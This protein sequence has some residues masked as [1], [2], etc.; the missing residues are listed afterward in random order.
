MLPH[1]RFNPLTREWVLVSP[2]RT[3]RPWQG[4]VEQGAGGQRPAYDPNCYLC[5]GNERAGGTRNPAYTD[6]YV[7]DNDYPALVPPSADGGWPMAQGQSPIP[8]YQLPPTTPSA[9]FLSHP[10]AGLCRVICFSPRHDLSLAELPEPALRRV[11]DAWAEQTTELNALPFIGYVQVFEN[12]GEMM[13]AS[14][15]HPH[16][17]VWASQHLPNEPA[18]ED[19]ALAAYEQAHGRCLV[20]DLV[21]AELAAGERVVCANEHFAAVVPFWAVWPFETLV[22]G[23]RHL[24]RLDELSA[25]ERDALAS[26]LKRLATRYDNLFQTSFPYSMGWHQRPAA[27]LTLAGPAWHLHAHFY[28]PLLRSATVRKFMVGYELMANP[29][30]DLTAEAAA[31]RLRA[32]PE[33]HYK[34]SQGK[35]A[36]GG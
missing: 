17:Q 23:R 15:P 34:D 19:A 16:G 14:N 4:Q 35:P 32:M 6:I 30:R 13:G 24:G 7:F 31:D 36:A 3:Q 20:C 10:E 22:A 18:K 12:K 1:R 11:V 5:P 21:A 26:L 27:P 8:N 33:V 25:A 2:Q 29:Q 28:P 9:L